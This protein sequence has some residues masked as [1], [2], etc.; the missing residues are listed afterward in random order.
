MIFRASSHQVSFFPEKKNLVFR[1][2]FEDVQSL[3]RA[4]GRREQCGAGNA[5]RREPVS[6]KRM[7]RGGETRNLRA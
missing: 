2:G 3:G 1:G 5:A 7:Q 4:G 6:G